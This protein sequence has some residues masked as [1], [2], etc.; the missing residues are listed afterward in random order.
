MSL[1]ITF[2]ASDFN[3]QVIPRFCIH[4]TINLGVSFASGT[5]KSPTAQQ[6]SGILLERS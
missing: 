5:H 3:P 4:N 6:K 2:R 1:K